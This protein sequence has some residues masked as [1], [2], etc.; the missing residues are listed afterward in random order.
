MFERRRGKDDAIVSSED[1]FKSQNYYQQSRE[2][3]LND[4]T[5][6]LH[7]SLTT[8]CGIILIYI[9]VCIRYSHLYT[10]LLKSILGIANIML[11]Y[12][13]NRVKIYKIN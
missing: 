4:N 9:G 2:K 3:C 7:G 1:I 5:F 8:A 11:Y 6:R 10:Y 12:L 13:H